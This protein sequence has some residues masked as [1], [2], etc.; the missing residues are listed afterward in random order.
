MS[1]RVIEG[2]NVTK[3]T[4]AKSELRILEKT[5]AANLEPTD[6]ELINYAY[7][8]V[9]HG[10]MLRAQQLLNKVSAGYFDMTIYRDLYDAQVAYFTKDKDPESAKRYEYLLTVRKC[11]ELFDPINFAEKPAFYRFRRDFQR[12]NSKV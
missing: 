12:I 5:V 6:R 3:I 1:L 7:L 8:Y 9:V 10:Q 4:D 11:L 2:G